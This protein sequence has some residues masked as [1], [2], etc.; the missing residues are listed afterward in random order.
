MK[1]PKVMK[2]QERVKMEI[3]L[4]KSDMVQSEFAPLGIAYI[5]ACLE[6]AGY[7][8]QILDLT[9]EKMPPKK[10]G[11][12]LE[13]HNPFIIGISAMIVEFE[14]VLKISSICKKFAHEAKVIVGGPITTRPEIILSQPSIDFVVI[15]EGEI[16]TVELIE[17]IKNNQPL[18]EVK[19][20]GYKVNGVPKINPPREHLDDLDIVPFPAR[21]LL[22]MKNYISPFENWFGKK[23][24]GD[25]IRATNIITSRGCPYRCI[26]CDKNVF[27][28]KWRG[29]T[30]KN[31]VDEIEFLMKEYDINGIIFNDDMFDL[32]RNRVFDLCDEIIRRKLIVVW[33]C[34]SRV[35]H[36]DKKVYQKM[37]EAGC[38]YVAFGVEFGNQN[39]LDFVQKDITIEQ[40]RNA[41]NLAKSVGL[42]TV[43]YSMIGMIGE[44]ERTIS[45]TIEFAKSLDLDSG[46]FSIVI[47]FP[48]TILF[49][50][51]AKEGFVDENSSW[52]ANNTQINLTKDLTRE[53]LNRL[54]NQAY[55][56]FF[57]SRP[58]RRAP[59]VVCKIFYNLF[60][61]FYL[62]GGNNF[63]RFVYNSYKILRFSRLSLP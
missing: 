22:S 59:K 49:D 48:G 37:Y 38:R 27:G 16:T 41:I 39:I 32:K 7:S 15:G 57:W 43:G 42:R 13:A 45:E 52:Q 46:G 58:S 61:I 10:I 6:K 47:P 55:W 5:G 21:H 20:I 63:G 8:V 44:N 34:N 33:G 51:A 36:A 2:Y 56:E 24:N 18:D 54:V 25:P 60:P 28:T 19:G 30:I 53:Q 1:G 26:Y 23:P 14:Q 40:I 17:K 4:I 62:V 11:A 12:F 35:N 29:R 31:I 50:L 9:V 3:V